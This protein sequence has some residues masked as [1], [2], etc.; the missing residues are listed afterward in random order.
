MEL[1]R[2]KNH[3]AWRL[4]ATF[5]LAQRYS[6]RWKQGTLLR[7]IHAT[8]K[9]CSLSMIGGLLWTASDGVTVSRAWTSGI[10]RMISRCDLVDA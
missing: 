6:F 9:G 3:T 10:G 2:T 1:T 7:P 4:P 5:P 8:A